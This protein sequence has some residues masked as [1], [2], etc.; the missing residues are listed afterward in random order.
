MALLMVS[1][2]G[3]DTFNLRTQEVSYALSPQAEQLLGEQPISYGDRLKL[4]AKNQAYVY[5]QGYQPG[6]GTDGQIG[7]P[8]FSASFS[9]DPKKGVTVTDV[10]NNVSVTFKPQFGLREP[11]QQGGKLVYPLLGSTAQ[12]VYTLKATS[13]KEDIVLNTPGADEQSFDYA[14][15]T[16][17]GT[18]VRIESDGSLGVYGVAS[19]LLGNVST[20]N[21]QDAQL[22]DQAR[23]N[24]KK[25][26]LLF[27]FPAPFIRQATK[28]PTTARAWFS[29][30]KNVLTVHATNLK[31][32]AY[33]LTID[34]TV[35]IETARKLM[36]GNN[37]SN[38]DF[39]VDNELIQKS[40]TTGARIDAWNNT[41]DLD[42]QLW[43]QGTAVAGGYIY[44]VGGQEVYKKIFSTQGSNS[45]KVPTGVTSISAKTW[46]AG[47]GGGG[48]G[49][50]ASGG[51]GGGSGY[52]AADMTV[53]AGE[54]LSL[55]V[56]G[57]GNGGLY[58]SGGVG[59]G[60]G[61]PA[62]RARCDSF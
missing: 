41:G 1:T 49:A 62:E 6:Q 34:P 32:A 31:E 47:G 15:E 27:R 3:I 11:R 40:Q 14:I 9:K 53:T 8:K 28:K 25:E 26:L 56:G 51:T 39:D 45:F 22:L 36:R 60:G 61:G 43:D 2:L 59:A 16:A 23:Q 17:S 7:G 44:S 46:S 12:K 18:E 52:I 54:T 13:L 55:Y 10:V 19:S 38:I 20:G 50:T 24:G 5:N 57:G 30:E 35:Y 42:Y 33:P 48:G 58:N 29:L 21:T 4:D 37:E